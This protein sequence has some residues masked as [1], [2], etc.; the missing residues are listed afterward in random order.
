MNSIKSITTLPNTYDAALK[1]LIFDWMTA[2]GSQPVPLQDPV[3]LLKDLRDIQWLVPFEVQNGEASDEGIIE[4]IADIQ[5]ENTVECFCETDF[6]EEFRVLIPKEVNENQKAWDG[7][8]FEAV[9]TREGELI[10]VELDGE[11]YG[12]HTTGTGDTRVKLVYEYE[13]CHGT[14]AGDET[15]E[16]TSLDQ[17]KEIADKAARFTG[18]SITILDRHGEEVCTRKWYGLPFDSETDP[19]ENIIDFGGFGYYA[20]WE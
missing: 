4:I 16:V 10:K 15:V 8:R 5:I 12:L 19:S 1:S 13:I 3:E 20:D 18:A 2:V 9:D 17:A 14:G 7:K 11:L 6:G